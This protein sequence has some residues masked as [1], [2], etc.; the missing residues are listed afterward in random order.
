MEKKFITR[1]QK[2]KV[3]NRLV[4]NFGILLAG[5][6][7]ML[8]VYKFVSAGYWNSVQNVLLVLGI[9]F[10]VGAVA[11]FILGKKKCPCLTKYAPILLGSFIV[12]G[13]VA[14][15]KFITSFPIKTAVISTF[16][17]MAVYFIV[18]AICTAIYLKTHTVVIEKKKIVHKKKRK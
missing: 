13:I 12:C 1:E 9:I 7:I 2:E 16:I 8:Y 18:M 11:T 3:S 17:E 4:L 14:S 15:T 10:A 5:A 6:W